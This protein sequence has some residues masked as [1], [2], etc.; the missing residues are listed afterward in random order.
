MDMYVRMSFLWPQLSTYLE[1]SVGIKYE[2]YLPP[3]T[4]V[5][6]RKKE[7][8]CMHASDGHYETED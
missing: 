3:A 4:Y 1:M 6:I 7:V 2:A 5:P 8:D